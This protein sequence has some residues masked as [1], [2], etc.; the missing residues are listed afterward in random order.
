MRLGKQGVS[1]PPPACTLYDGISANN[2]KPIVN[3]RCLGRISR[4]P[5]PCL[6]DLGRHFQAD[7]G[8]SIQHRRIT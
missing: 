8:S 4:M 3:G 2:R 1:D 7:N 6:M 5:D